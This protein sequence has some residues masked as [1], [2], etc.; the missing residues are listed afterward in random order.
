MT[1]SNLFLSPIGLLLYSV[2]GRKKSCLAD[3]CWVG[4][5]KERK[6]G[7]LDERSLFPPL[8]SLSLNMYLIFFIGLGGHSLKINK[9]RS[10]LAFQVHDFA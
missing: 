3:T 2:A 8:R 9:M 5:I 1:F 4:W 6:G 7:I 10:S